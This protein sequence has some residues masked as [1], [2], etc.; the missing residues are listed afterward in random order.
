MQ[1]FKVPWGQ[2]YEQSYRTLTFPD[3]WEVHFCEPEYC[4]EISDE[5]IIKA[6]DSP[7]GTEKLEKLAEGKKS[8]CIIIDDISRP[9]PG[10]RLL[11]IVIRKLVSA[12]LAYENIKVLVAL[13]GH[14]PM[15]RQ[16]MKIKVGAWVL[17]HVQVINH[18]AFSPDLVTIPDKDQVIRINRNYVEADLKIA[19]GCIVPHTLAGF[20]GG[21]KAVIPGIGGIETLRSN[22]TLVFADKSK[23][24]S[25]KTST[26]D[27]DNA[28]RKN[29]EE[30]VGKVG[31]DFIVN[32]VL[33]SR[34]K[35]AE[36]FTGHFVKAHRAACVR[37]MD[38]LGTK[39]VKN[40]D[41]TVTSAY[42]K[43]TEYSQIATCFAVLGHY[44]EQCVAKDG[45]LVAMTA[46]SEGAG[47]HALFGPGMSL[48]SPHDDNMPPLELKDKELY[49]LS[50]GVK[51]TDIRQ[52]YTGE[53]PP[54]Y[55]SWEE[56]LEKLEK[57]Y[58]GR[59]PVVAI[60]PMGA[61]SIGRLDQ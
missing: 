28:M 59:K 35:V 7:I 9:T 53:T 36:V 20:S 6:I 56:V 37:A 8:A 46:A 29:M 19:V 5:G 55:P 49:I 51:Q 43:D 23:S 12:G 11:P 33:N 4:E 45:T 24:M 42:P 10:D 16:E 60:Y 27:P 52:F 30:I 1:E 25:F 2:W 54:V 14:R 22:H 44:K 26:C 15:T 47:F 21:A 38:R 18:F 50:D 57:K 3:E 34:M 48:F 17:D 13:G 41:I 61:V 58:E 32:V 40:A 39:L 31:L